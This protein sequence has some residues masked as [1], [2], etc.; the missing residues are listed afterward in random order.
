M[1]FVIPA[2]F[3]AFV[4]S[5]PHAFAAGDLIT[6]DKTLFVQFAIF[7][8]AL[9]LLN[10]LFFRPLMELADR[11]EKATSGSGREA[12]ELVKKA[13]EMTGQ[14]N[15]AI[16]EAR[17]AALEERTR[18]TKSALAEAEDIVSSAREDARWILE[19]RSAELSIQAEK[20]RND[21]KSELEDMAAMIVQAV[22][23]PED[24]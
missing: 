24:V 17:D 19:K 15:V 7:L 14:Y 10:I 22:E 1:R 20:A 21:L 12:D 9:Y 8:V 23:K 3:S 16:K 11:R 13:E 5:T 4:L 6:A 18:I 2:I